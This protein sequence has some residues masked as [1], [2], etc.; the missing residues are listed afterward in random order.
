MVNLGS[1]ERKIP[2]SLINDEKSTGGGVIIKADIFAT[3][4]E[5]DC[6]KEQNGILGTL[7]DLW[8]DISREIEIL[9]KHFPNRSIQEGAADFWFD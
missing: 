9:D 7:R 3:S 5:A 8:K 6:W 1:S 2:E 4:E